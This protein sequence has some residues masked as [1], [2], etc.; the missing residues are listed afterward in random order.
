MGRSEVTTSVVASAVIIT[1]LISILVGLLLVALL[2]IV[3]C[4]IDQRATDQARAETE[5]SS[6]GHPHASA[7][8]LLGPPPV[9]AIATSHASTAESSLLRITTIPSLL[10]IASIALLGV[11]VLRLLLWI[12]SSLLGVVTAAIAAIAAAA[13][14]IASATAAAELALTGPK[15]L[16]QQALA[17]GLALAGRQLVGVRAG[18]LAGPG[19]RVHIAR[20]GAAA[21]AEAAAGAGVLLLLQLAS[22]LGVPVD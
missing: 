11:P 18:T 6:T 5:R 9:A 13:A 1:V 15:D 3:E 17:L 22:E 20:G 21:A 4:L 8:R 10:R 2:V 7:A 12:I 14:A 16:A 19:T